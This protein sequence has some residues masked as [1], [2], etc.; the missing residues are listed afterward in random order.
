MASVLKAVDGNRASGKVAVV[1]DGTIVDVGTVRRELD[2]MDGPCVLMAF[3]LNTVVDEDGNNV[4][5]V[6]DDTLVGVDTVQGP[7]GDRE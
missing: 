6:T 2:G 4:S 3:V 1:T 5:M 7:L